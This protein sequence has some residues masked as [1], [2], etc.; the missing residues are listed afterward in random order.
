MA[1][2][3]FTHAELSDWLAESSEGKLSKKQAGD[4]V[5]AVFGKVADEVKKGNNVKM[6]GL[7]TAKRAERAERAGQ[8]P[9]TKEK[10]TI[11][12]HYALKVEA[13]KSVAEALKEIP[14]TGER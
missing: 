5:K 1:A 6:I 3:T 9:L 12:A 8:N 2:V 13:E 11:P 14:Y 7:G 10:I 4:F